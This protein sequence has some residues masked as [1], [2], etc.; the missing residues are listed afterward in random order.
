MAMKSSKHLQRMYML[1]LVYLLPL[2]ALLLW[3]FEV[4]LNKVAWIE[5]SNGI[6]FSH[7]GQVIALSPSASLLHDLQEGIGLAVEV[8]VSTSDFYQDGPARIVSYS[9]NTLLRNFTLGQFQNKLVIR[10]R[11]SDTDPNGVL[12][13]YAIDDV[14]VSSDPIHIVVTYDFL[15]FNIYINGERKARKD[16]PSDRFASWDPSYYFIL[17]N[18]ATG[19]RPW[20]GNIYY[21]AVYNEPLTQEI[22]DLHYGLGWRPC[23]HLR[24]GPCRSL[25]GLIANYAFEAGQGNIVPE[26]IQSEN[27][28]NLHIPFIVTDVEKLYL[29]ASID[30][31]NLREFM[32]VVMNIIG[33]IP[34][35]ILLHFI[36]T[37]NLGNSFKSAT[38]T[39][40]L[41]SFFSFSME[42]IQ[43]FVVGR[44]SSIIDLFCN[45]LGIALGVLVNSARKER[46]AGKVYLSEIADVE[47]A[48]SSLKR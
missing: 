17:G 19:D 44:N 31:M 1:F 33:F 38:I 14:F 18:E 30:F 41:G 16:I 34:F 4:R 45:M 11:T 7:P 5:D 39:F 10:Y 15:E 29:S 37:R 12:S 48:Q 46:V 43:F 47:K 6:S 26:S 23:D 22:V 35:G 25:D 24:D 32:D 42:S 40:L 27:S 13:E 28:I 2:L 36:I 8:W 9:L 20:V 3:P 21:L